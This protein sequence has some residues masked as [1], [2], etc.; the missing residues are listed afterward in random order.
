MKNPWFRKGFDREFS[1]VISGE[2]VDEKN[3]EV[4]LVRSKSL[5]NPPFYNAFEFISSM[6]SGL[7]LSSLFESKRKSY[8]M[9]T[10]KCSASDI[11]WESGNNGEE[12]EFWS[13]DGEKSGGAQEREAGGGLRCGTR[14][15]DGGAV[16]V[17]RRQCQV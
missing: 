1:W 3:G 16:E 4:E 6:S 17:R 11:I 9:F 14:G 15:D 13:E 8:S 5:S 2:K 10:S 7:D 12:A